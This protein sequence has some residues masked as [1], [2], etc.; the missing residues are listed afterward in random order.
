MALYARYSRLLSCESIPVISIM[1]WW[2]AISSRDEIISY[3]FFRT[4]FYLFCVCCLFIPIL[5]EDL[6]SST[7]LDCLE[8][9]IIVVRFWARVISKSSIGF[10]RY[11]DISLSE[12]ISVVILPYPIDAIDRHYHF[13]IGHFACINLT[14]RGITHLQTLQILRLL[15]SG[16]CLHMSMRSLL[17]LFICSLASLNLL[18]VLFPCTAVVTGLVFSYPHDT[19]FNG[20]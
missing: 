20:A 7:L 18:T 1:H 6:L 15:N 11:S 2:F 14:L 8:Q 3:P 13:P 12:R 17:I 10:F 16:H 4:H 19:H 9:N 5:I